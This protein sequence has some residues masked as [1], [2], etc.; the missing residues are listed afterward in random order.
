MNYAPEP[1]K[2]SS[3]FPILNFVSLAQWASAIDKDLTGRSWRQDLSLQ[4]QNM[5]PSPHRAPSTA[6]TKFK[7][8]HVPA[9]IWVSKCWSQC[10]KG[11]IGPLTDLWL[12]MPLVEVQLHTQ[13]MVCPVMDT[14][15][16]CWTHYSQGREGR[17]YIF[18]NLIYDFNISTSTNKISRD[19]LGRGGKV[20]VVG[21]I[22]PS[23]QKCPN[24]WNE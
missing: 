1:R 7:L 18:G 13:S 22:L 24:T 11:P 17:A 4:W 19:I 23:P 14:E 6:S 2:F 15:E 21:R 16:V 5:W 3:T 10:C 20:P 9:H 12:E 8:L